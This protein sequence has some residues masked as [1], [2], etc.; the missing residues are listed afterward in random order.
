MTIIDNTSTSIIVHT[1]SY[2][3]I[4]NTKIILTITDTEDP[5]LIINVSTMIQKIHYITKTVTRIILIF[6][7]V[8]SHCCNVVLP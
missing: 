5:I 1:S 2:Y 6:K 3:T 4:Y 8:G 7:S